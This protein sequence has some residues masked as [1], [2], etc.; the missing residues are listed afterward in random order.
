MTV[1]C[2]KDARRS[3]WLKSRCVNGSRRSV[4]P[5]S[6][7]PDPWEVK[8]AL[9]DVVKDTRSRRDATQEERRPGRLDGHRRDYGSGTVFSQPNHAGAFKLAP[10]QSQQ[11]ACGLLEQLEPAV[12]KAFCSSL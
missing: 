11:P 3:I 6:E 7:D 4:Q 1:K 12:S 10:F 5:P 8:D 2:S 9:W